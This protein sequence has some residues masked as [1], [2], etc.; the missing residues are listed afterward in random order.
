[1]LISAK[2]EILNAHKYKNIKTFSF[3]SGSDK[4]KVLFYM[5]INFKMPIVVGRKNF[6]LGEHEIFL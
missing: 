1:M 5:P 6:M 4:P 2:Y 3:F